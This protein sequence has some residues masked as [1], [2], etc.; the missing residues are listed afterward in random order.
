MHWTKKKRESDTKKLITLIADNQSQTKRQR[1]RLMTT[2][3]C[4]NQVHKGKRILVGWFCYV[5]FR[6]PPLK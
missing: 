3:N 1:T 5:Q 4:K 2:T 6:G